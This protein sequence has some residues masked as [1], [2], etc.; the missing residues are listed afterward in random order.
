MG[1]RHCVVAIIGS[2]THS[3]E[4][5]PYTLS[6]IQHP[7]R[8]NTYS[9]FPKFE[10][11]QLRRRPHMH[12]QGY[13]CSMFETSVRFFPK[14]N[15]PHFEMTESVCERARVYVFL[16]LCSDNA[17]CDLLFGLCEMATRTEPE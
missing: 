7:T 3:D 15:L 6:R 4:I 16:H 5:A 1:A 13:T 17:I 14:E 12:L 8:S 10:Y 9:I 2:I 11:G